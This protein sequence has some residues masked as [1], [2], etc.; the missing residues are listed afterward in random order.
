ASRRLSS[1]RLRAS[2]LDAGIGPPCRCLPC[3]VTHGGCAVCPRAMVAHV[4]VCVQCGHAP[5]WTHPIGRTRSGGGSPVG[6]SRAGGGWG[7]A[8]DGTRPIVDVAAQGA[9]Q[10]RTVRGGPLTL[11]G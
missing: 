10:G 6:G 9:D 8:S 11:R 5:D 2:L 7:H 1:W 3:R 4:S